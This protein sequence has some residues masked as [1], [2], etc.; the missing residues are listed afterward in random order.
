MKSLSVSIAKKTTYIVATL[1]IVAAL[2]VAAS[3]IATPY[4]DAHRSDIEQWAGEMLQA[5]I[6]IES[7]RVFVVSISTRRGAAECD[8]AG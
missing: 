2:L 1:I 6:K 4:L 7:A 3:R 8:A 5:P